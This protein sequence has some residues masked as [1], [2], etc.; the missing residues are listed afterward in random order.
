[1]VLPFFYYPVFIVHPCDRPDKGGCSDKCEKKGENK[2][3]ACT[4]KGEVLQKDGKK[5]KKRK[6]NSLY[7]TTSMK[8]WKYTDELHGWETNAKYWPRYA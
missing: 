3:C 4:K 6:S 1:M 2:V 5:C 8:L 7:L